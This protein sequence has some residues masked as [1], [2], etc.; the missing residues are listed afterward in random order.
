M[1][2]G[3]DRGVREG[4]RKPKSDEEGFDAGGWEAVTRTHAQGGKCTVETTMRG[5]IGAGDD[6][7][8]EKSVEELSYSAV[9]V[10]RW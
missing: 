4:V 2:R 3:K 5:R 9:W 7:R 8:E 6:D 10:V 1:G